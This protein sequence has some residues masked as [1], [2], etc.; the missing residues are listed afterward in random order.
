ADVGGGFTANG[1]VTLTGDGV[2]D[3]GYITGGKG[4]AATGSLTTVR[5]PGRTPVQ[6][7]QHL[8]LTT[9]WWR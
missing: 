8:G 9:W 5:A 3:G 7:G 1:L 6:I 4:V 2:I